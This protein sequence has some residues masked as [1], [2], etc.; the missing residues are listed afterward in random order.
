MREHGLGVGGGATY[1]MTSLLDHPDFRDEHLAMMPFAG[2]GGSPVP[3]R[4]HGAAAFPRHP[5]LP[6]VR[7]HRA[8]FHHRVPA[9]RPRGQAARN[10]RSG[11]ARR[12][13]P[14][15]RRRTDPEPGPGLLRRL[16]RSG[17]HA[18]VFDGDGWYHTGDIGVLDDEGYLT[19]TDRHQRRHHPGRR[20]H[21]RPGGRGGADGG[22]PAV[23]EVCVVA[24]PDARLGERAAA[25]VRCARLAPAPTLEDVRATSPVSA[26]PDRSGPSRCTWSTSSPG[27]LPERCRSS[28][29]ATSCRTGWSEP[30]EGMCYD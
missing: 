19:I 16:H 28:G 20:E 23:A 15:R 30:M 12:G 10:R 17:A 21:Q 8:P 1:F 14:P 22:S 9:R 13:D 24:A 6:L 5:G 11:P 4:R 27:R 2:L 7:Q 25:V 26:W 29:S 18:T 3:A